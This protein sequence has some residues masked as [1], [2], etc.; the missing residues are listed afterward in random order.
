MRDEMKETGGAAHQVNIGHRQRLSNQTEHRVLRGER[1]DSKRFSS[2]G[3]WHHFWTHKPTISGIFLWRLA[4]FKDTLLRSADR[5]RKRGEH[6]A[7]HPVGFELTTTWSHGVRSTVL[8]LPL[9]LRAILLYR[10]IP[11]KNISVKMRVRFFIFCAKFFHYAPRQD[12]NPWAL[13]PGWGGYYSSLV[14]TTSRAPKRFSIIALSR[15]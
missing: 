4:L 7:Q 10:L 12:S 13:A 3:K 8:Q 2:T 11:S 1:S 14:F 9:H 5:E 6:K 15:L